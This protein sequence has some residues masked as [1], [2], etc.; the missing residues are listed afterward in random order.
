MLA[1]GSYKDIQEAQEQV[2]EKKEEE[3]ESRY[4]GLAFM[5]EDSKS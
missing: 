5:R 2:E 1:V 4:T 3:K